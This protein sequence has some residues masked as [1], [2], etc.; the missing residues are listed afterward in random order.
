MNAKEITQSTLKRALND[1]IFLLTMTAH[2]VT[3]EDIEHRVK[4]II[5]YLEKTKKEGEV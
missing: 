1:P 2:E 4:D 3:P 5:E